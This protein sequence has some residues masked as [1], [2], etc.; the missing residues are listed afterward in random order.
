MNTRT[1]CEISSIGGY[2][3]S[4]HMHCLFIKRPSFWEARAH[5]LMQ[6]TVHVLI[7]QFPVRSGPSFFFLEVLSALQ[8]TVLSQNTVVKGL[9][10]AVQLVSVALK[11]PNNASILLTKAA[12]SNQ[13]PHL[14]YSLH[15]CVWADETEGVRSIFL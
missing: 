11:K 5:L 4:T 12:F 6:T 8:K 1:S 10:A 7:A 15:L 9:S 3:N 13:Y 2:Y 14:G